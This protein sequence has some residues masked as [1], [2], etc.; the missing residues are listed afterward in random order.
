MLLNMYKYV[1]GDKEGE[2]KEEV[3]IDKRMHQ[4]ALSLNNR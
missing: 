3:F 1:E 4:V 2:R